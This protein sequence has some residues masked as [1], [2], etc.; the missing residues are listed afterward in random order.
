MQNLQSNN[1]IFHLTSRFTK[2]HHL[3]LTYRYENRSLREVVGNEM[4]IH[5]RESSRDSLS[6]IHD[7]HSQKL[8]GMKKRKKK[9]D[10][11]VK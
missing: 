6:F 9:K 7:M 11:K 8:D 4:E 2:L 1:S 3:P 5:N 10:L